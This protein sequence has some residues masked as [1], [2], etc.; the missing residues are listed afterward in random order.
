MKLQMIDTKGKF[1]K[2]IKS[3]L[4]EGPIREDIMS[5][6]ISSERIHQQ[7][8]PKFR[9]GMDRSASGNTSK[10]R[11]VW[12]TDRGRGLP[13]LPRKI[14]WRRGT[15]FNWE[16]AIVPSTRGGRRAHPPHGD[17]PIKKINKKEFN[18]A[19]RS[20]LSFISTKELIQKK[21][22]RL[23]D[24]KIFPTF[25]LIISTDFLAQKTKDSLTTLRS[26]LKDMFVVAIQEKSIR[27]GRG[28]LRGRK[29]KRNAGLLFVTGR[30]EQKKMSGIE[31][32]PSH[33]LTVTDLAEGGA[34]LVMF[35][36]KAIN[37]LEEAFVK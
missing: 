15:Q 11:K 16:A 8:S 17:V 27:S 33:E 13:R 2:E 10:R 6:V 21:Y 22:A 28:T 18:I 9:A 24:S 31:I 29:Y 4:F 30:D 7:Y 32:V 23:K 34:R 12:K 14:F 35:T 20:A 19:M 25:P 26:I 1:G 37:E 36:E 3:E 5:K